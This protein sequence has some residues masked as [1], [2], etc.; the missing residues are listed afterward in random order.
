MGS[1][2]RGAPAAGSA[3]WRGPPG[4]VPG[5]R[6]AAAAPTACTHTCPH[7]VLLAVTNGP[8][9]GQLSPPAAGLAPV[10]QHATRIP[11]GSALISLPQRA[12]AHRARAPLHAHVHICICMCRVDGTA[13]LMLDAVRS[14][15]QLA[16]AGS[17]LVQ[18]PRRAVTAHRG[19]LYGNGPAGTSRVARRRRIRPPSGSCTAHRSISGNGFSTTPPQPPSRPLQRRAVTSVPFTFSRASCPALCNR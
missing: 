1:G 8:R 12:V 19:W 10:M 9:G 2:L 6:Y 15:S 14:R 7:P 17:R 18:R 3:V 11:Y 4:Q 13:L 16:G 5:S